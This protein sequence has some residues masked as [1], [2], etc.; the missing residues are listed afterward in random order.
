MVI[1]ME[2]SMF[3]KINLL[4]CGLLFMQTHSVDRLT[5]FAASCFNFVLKYPALIWGPVIILASKNRQDRLY[6]DDM[7]YFKNLEQLQ[8]ERGL[9]NSDTKRKIIDIAREQG[10]ELSFVV[11]CPDDKNFTGAY[12]KS[13]TLGALI[14]GEGFGF[15]ANEDHNLFNAK[16]KFVIHHE[17]SHI[18]DNHRS[19]N[20]GTDALFDGL[21]CA[22]IVQ[23][24]FKWKPV[25]GIL[26]ALTLNKFFSPMIR[27]YT[28][29]RADRGACKTVELV[30]GGIAFFTERMQ[31]PPVPVVVDAKQST[32]FLSRF[33][34]W[35]KARPFVHPT[36]QKRIADLQRI[37]ERMMAEN[38]SSLMGG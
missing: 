23:S 38:F 35:I 34:R 7:D 4:L 26:T 19:L 5:E 28:E 3:K 10:I 20:S 13:S 18:K 12:I 25:V 32:F 24:S 30:D 6:R 27:R 11:H 1:G 22:S 15:L 29:S 17:L 33:F 8:E 31:R 36:R 21:I 9:I 14:V 16:A 2:I 37:K